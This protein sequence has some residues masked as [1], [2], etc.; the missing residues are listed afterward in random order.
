MWCAAYASSSILRYRS[1][2]TARARDI[3]L[4]AY[5]NIDGLEQKTLSQNKM[6]QFANS[7]SSYPLVNKRT[8]SLSEVTAE[9]SSNRP[10]YISGKN[11]SDSR[12]AFVIRGYN[13]YV[14]FY[15]L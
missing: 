7:V 14:G 5:G 1:K 11:L 2:S 8:L 15:S 13:N 9:I 6:I 10:I 4:F 3:M 12:H